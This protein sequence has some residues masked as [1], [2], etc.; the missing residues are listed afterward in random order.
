MSQCCRIYAT[1]DRIPQAE[2][3]GKISYSW[4]DVTFFLSARLGYICY[5]FMQASTVSLFWSKIGKRKNVSLEDSAL[6]A[7]CEALLK[8]Q[9]PF[10]LL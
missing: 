10:S 8:Y 7:T 1:T 4:L 5:N 2:Y 3:L 6:P 9:M